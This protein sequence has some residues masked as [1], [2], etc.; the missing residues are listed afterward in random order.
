MRC[1]TALPSEVGPAVQIRVPPAESPRTIGSA[2]DFIFAQEPGADAMERA[3]PGQRIGHGS[4]AVADDL[5]DDTLIASPSS[6]WATN[7]RRS[8]ITEHSFHGIPKG[9]G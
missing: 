1:Q 3:G 8:S 5:P 4:S 9:E 7:C 2:G 6:S